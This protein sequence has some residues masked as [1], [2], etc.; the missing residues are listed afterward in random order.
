M[1]NTITRLFTVSAITWGLLS[2]PQQINI[3]LA[4]VAPDNS[5]EERALR[6]MGA[7]IATETDGRVRLTLFAGGFAGTEI[8]IL[9]LMRGDT[10]KAT[11]M[12]PFGLAEVDPGFNVFAVPFFLENL[13]EQSA[14]Q[15]RLGA[16]I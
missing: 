14:V 6:D 11:L 1:S 8:A 2:P 4:T 12:S 15:K 10:I 7:T 16:A 9:R 3:K 13:D 5:I